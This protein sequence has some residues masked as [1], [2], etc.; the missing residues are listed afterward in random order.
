[1]FSMHRIPLGWNLYRGLVGFY[2]MDSW[3]AAQRV[4]FR[5]GSIES[6]WTECRQCPLKTVVLSK[7]LQWAKYLL[8]LWRAKVVYVFV[9]GDW[10]NR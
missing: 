5:S 2:V 1:M 6:P 4:I 10:G 7:S 8:Y 9:S 3:C